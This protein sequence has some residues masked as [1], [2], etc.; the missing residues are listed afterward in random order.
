MDRL[1]E[2]AAQWGVDSNYIDAHGQPQTVAPEAL[3]RIVSALA[4]SHASPTRALPATFVIRQNRD[5]RLSLPAEFAGWEWRVLQ[6]RVERARGHVRDGHIDLPRELEPGC[7]SL[8]VGDQH[9]LLLAAPER[10]Y[11]CQGPGREKLW[12]LG[13]QLYGLRSDRNWGYG[14][15][16]DLLR[17]IDLAAELGAAGIALNPIHA[18]FDDRPE[19]NSPYAPNSRLFIN[20]LYIDVGAIPEFPGVEAA[21]MAAEIARLRQPDVVDYTGVAAAKLRGLRLAYERFRTVGAAARPWRAS[22]PSRYCGAASPRCG[23]TGRSRG[24]GPATPTWPRCDKSRRRSSAC[25]NTSNGSPTRSCA[26]A[27]SA[28]NRTG[29]PS[30][31]ISTLRSEWTPAAPTPGASPKRSSPACRSGLRPT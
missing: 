13:V 26:S 5:H 6:D 28:R 19:Q 7:Y 10:A 30:A 2:L 20:T 29:L 14:D 3:S 9:S 31:S 11:Q 16:G 22:P 21:G 24:G 17:L 27:A 4:A 1:S 23:G 18:L 15:F 12:V 8:I 25:M